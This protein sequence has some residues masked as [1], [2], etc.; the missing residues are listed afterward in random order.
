M[1]SIAPPPS[2]A[3]ASLLDMSFDDGFLLSHLPVD[4]ALTWPTTIFLA[5]TASAN[6]VTTAPTPSVACASQAAAASGLFPLGRA[7][8]EPCITH[9]PP[10][11]RTS[12]EDRLVPP[13]RIRDF[14]D[15]KRQAH[16][17][18]VGLSTLRPQWGH[19]TAAPPAVVPS[20]PLPQQPAPLPA[21]LQFKAKSSARMHAVMATMAQA[22][23]DEMADHAATRH[24]QAVVHADL[25][26]DFETG[27][28]RVVVDFNESSM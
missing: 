7:H 25:W 23:H 2:E 4:D 6:P 20:A 16:A 15:A 24:K 17:A 8:S 27:K 21:E 26:S 3:E 12:S 5:D 22:V 18:D 9:T 14:R 11:P 28:T 19:S 1:T 10:L 13:P